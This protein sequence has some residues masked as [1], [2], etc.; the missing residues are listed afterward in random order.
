MLYYSAL[1]SLKNGKQHCVGAATGDNPLGPFE[2]MDEPLICPE[3]GSIDVRPFSHDGKRYLVYKVGGHFNPLGTHTSMIQIRDLDP[4]GTI[5]SD[6][7]TTLITNTTAEYD[8][9]GPAMT[10]STDGKTFFLFFVTGYY[11]KDTYA[12]QYTS[13]PSPLGPFINADHETLFK[14]GTYNDV[15]LL[16]PGAPSF[17]NSTYMSFMTTAPNEQCEVGDLIRR[18]HTVQV[19]YNGDT[20]KVASSLNAKSGVRNEDESKG[21]RLTSSSVTL[22]LLSGFLC[23]FLSTAIL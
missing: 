5:V 1:K 9:E 4:T 23:A 11:Q 17:I 8:T 21:E 15:F 12:I 19:S 20:V 16:A 18:M 2:P 10:I 6:N 13:A 7:H 14:T 3:Q 22:A